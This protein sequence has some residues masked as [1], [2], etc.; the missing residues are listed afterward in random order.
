MG[1]ECCRWV[2]R[3]ATAYNLKGVVFLGAPRRRALLIDGL[4]S[5]MKGGGL[6]FQASFFIQGY[7]ERFQPTSAVVG[8]IDFGGSPLAPAKKPAFF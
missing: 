8:W 1:E 2:E 3:K 7:P 4:A 5:I 6:L